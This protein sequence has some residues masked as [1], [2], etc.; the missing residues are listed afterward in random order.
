MADQ[1]NALEELVFLH[2]LL[3]LSCQAVSTHINALISLQQ[4]RLGASSEQCS[5]SCMV[6][7]NC[8]FCR[9]LLT[10]TSCCRSAGKRQPT[11]RQAVPVQL[12]MPRH[13]Q[14]YGT[15]PLDCCSI[16]M[17][18]MQKPS[19]VHAAL[20]YA[21][22]GS[23]PDWPVAMSHLGRE[24]M[25]SAVCQAS[26]TSPAHSEPVVKSNLCMAKQILPLLAASSQWADHHKA[27]IPDIGCHH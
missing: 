17:R 22:R 20:C 23:V 6:A 13:L 7:A 18:R 16:S 21:W 4:H 2:G 14:H 24:L 1:R 9:K 8:G 25:Q 26:T 19:S 27:T 12:W 11:G 5:A 3:D 10:H 15:S